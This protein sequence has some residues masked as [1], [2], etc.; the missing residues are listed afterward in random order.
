MRR[1][2][3]GIIV[4]L[5]AEPQKLRLKMEDAMASMNGGANPAYLGLLN[6]ISLAEGRAGVYLTAWAEATSDE[7]LA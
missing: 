5:N 4:R 1:A 2:R 6:A 3:F 7:D